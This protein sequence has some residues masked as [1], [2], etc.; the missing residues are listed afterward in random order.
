VHVIQEARPD[1]QFNP[2]EAP[3]MRVEVDLPAVSGNTVV[4]RWRQSDPNPFQYG[5][6][7]FFRYE[8][9]DLSRF[10]P[11]LLVEILLGLQ[12]KVFAAYGVPVE[13]VLPV[14]V[15]RPSV[16]FWRAF[17]DADLVTVTPIADVAFY[18][19]W[20]AP[21]VY[22]DRARTAAVYFGGGKDSTLTA[23]LLAELY[24]PEAVL[25]IQYIG[26]LRSDPVLT[27]RLERRQE[28]LMLRPAR[29]HFGV[30]TQ[31][32]WTDYQAR[33]R[34][35]GY[36]ARPD[37]E[38]YTLGALPVLLFHRLA[39]CTF[40]Y[41]W[42]EFGVTRDGE[43]RLRFRNP[44][45]RPEMLQ[46]QSRHY[47]RVLGA[48][49]TV[50]NLNFLFSGLGVFRT[51]AE[52]YPDAM[53]HIVPCTHGAVGERW[54]YQ[55]R[56][57]AWYPF[58]GLHCGYVDPTFD[59]DRLFGTCSYL[60]RMVDYAASGVELSEHGNAPVH[61]S[62][63]EDHVFPM[64]CHVVAGT[65]LDLVRSRIGREARGNLLTLKALFG[66]RCYPGYEAI[67]AKTVDLLGNDLARH[68]ANIAANY[69]EVVDE[70][71]TSTLSDT[72]QEVAYDFGVRMPTRTEHL[73]HLRP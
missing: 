70:L 66:H 9:V 56:K 49:V 59:Y 35:A 41:A 65:D 58:F 34:R 11:T 63:G 15:P 62:L 10:S 32:V 3:V 40:S 61:P 7:F 14:A 46:T 48:D 5:N 21:P 72:P 38:L 26:P 18:D 36:H 60:Q 19:P 25:L 12:L 31:R 2:C 44:K 29:T 69:L 24:G 51:L 54:C 73:A 1:L 55:C 43:G 13:V 39:L 52:R 68:V 22:A 27:R 67:P 64:F 4:F 23:R 57:C 28:A 16:E 30:G 6:R 33:F 20:S 17:H 45:A 42:T 37:L 8:H 71:A 53:A 50:T 47:R